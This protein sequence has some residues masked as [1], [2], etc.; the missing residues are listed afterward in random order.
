MPQDHGP[1]E[2]TYKLTYQSNVELA[3]QQKMSHFEA[4]FTFHP[5]L[6]GRTTQLLDLVGMTEAREDAPDSGDT[7]DIG[8]DHGQVWC[9]P[10]RIDW[11]RLVKKEISVKAAVDYTSS[12]VQGGAAAVVRKKDDI[13]AAAFFGNKLTGQDGL[14]ST[15]YDGASRTVD[16]TVGSID[17]ATNTGMNVKK[18]LRAFRYLEEADVTIEDEE[19][20]LALTPQE[21]EELYDDVT[22]VSKDYRG[23]AV[24]EDKRVRQILGITILPTTVKRL[25]N[26]DANTH[27]APLWC[28]RGMHYGEF[29][30]LSTI[31]ER[32]PNKQYRLH[33]YMEMFLGATRGE[34]ELV[35][36]I[37][38]HIP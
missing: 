38:N 29:D 33:P 5:G 23:R 27:Y 32:N 35:I 4:A 12:Y 25:P 17:G 8:S 30:P 2:E 20:F 14:T 7:P 10:K 37:T 31:I 3:V 13:L 36:R 22:Y 28:K 1:V 9:K 24:I 11:G 26:E 16:K 19:I 15:A 18:I 6:K 34:D 21:N